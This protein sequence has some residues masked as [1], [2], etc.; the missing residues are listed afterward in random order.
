M[1]YT[2]LGWVNDRTPALNE[3]NLNH[4]DQGIYDAHQKLSEYEDIF[5]GDVDESVQNW[6]DEHPEAT[7]TVQDN[8]L[9]TVK[10]RDGSVTESK[11]SPA[12]IKAN[13]IN[14]A[15][16]VEN[17]ALNSGNIA[18]AILDA[19]EVGKNLYI[20][21]GN[22]TFNV[23]ITTDCII[24]LDTEC[25]I[26][27]NNSTPCIYASGCS[28]K[29]IGGNIY[30]GANDDTRA[31]VYGGT[32]SSKSIISFEDCF[33]CVISNI[34][35]PHS[36][37]GSVYQIKDCERV[38]FENLSLNNYLLSGIRIIDHCV[39]VIVRNCSFV[40]IDR[41][42]GHDYCY[43][44]STGSLSLDNTFIPPDGLI[45]ENNYVYDSEDCALDTHGATNVIIRNN[46][47]KETVNA[48]TAYNDNRRVKRPNNW[49]MRDILVENN[50]CESTRD[51]E[52]GRDY[53][54]PY[55]F[56]G[57]I[58]N[59][60]DQDPG[61]E[62]NYGD[63]YSYCN[64][65]VQNNYIKS[66]NSYA[67]GLITLSSVSRNVIIRNNVIDCCGVG[68]PA[69]FRR[70]INFEFKNNSILNQSN[71]PILFVAS[72]GE[73]ANNT[74]ARF[75]YVASNPSRIKGLIGDVLQ[76]KSPLLEL[77]D[78]VVVSDVLYICTSYGVR[79]RS[80]VT[81]S[82]FSVTITDGVAE[83]DNNIYLPSMSLLLNNTTAAYVLDVIDMR[84]MILVNLSGQLIPDG[85][86]TAT[87]RA[88]TVNAL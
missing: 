22:Y 84:R 44:V 82:S 12:L 57:A 48:I 58:N 66:P 52:S 83:V 28:I 27:T 6:L 21:S 49:K 37:Y 24:V 10:Y 67:E 5:T 3:T 50:Y 46:T 80:G 42:T 73:I 41:M 47:I 74:N 68:R 39:D 8:S 9:T 62:D 1:A 86:Y 55:I 34:K 32:D 79:L 76:Y 81:M 31:P 2:K 77:G 60:T 72:C 85:A 65:I 35:T 63:Y 16:M 23:S 51:N 18:Q 43:A 38:L 40:N 78:L 13:F 4:M 36:K 71:L 54:H 29:L 15:S 69:S 26:A 17:Y 61:Y 88:A 20:P 45:Y 56:L 30:A 70:S 75:D 19:L 7:T 33:D 59:N 25:Y 87:V 11:I 64:C 14:V 53:P